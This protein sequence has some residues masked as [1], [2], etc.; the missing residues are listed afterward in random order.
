MN[1]TNLLERFVGLAFI[2]AFYLWSTKQI[3]DAS[4][5]GVKKNMETLSND[6]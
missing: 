6:E 3:Y 5:R 1:L 2:I 4:M